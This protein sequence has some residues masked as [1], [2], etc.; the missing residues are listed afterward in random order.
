MDV[1]KAMLDIL[2]NKDI[3]LTASA[4]SSQN[5]SA[6]ARIAEAQ[7]AFRKLYKL[8]AATGGDTDAMIAAAL[9]AANGISSGPAAAS[10]GISPLGD[11]PFSPASGFSTSAADSDFEM[12]QRFPS[13]LKV[14]VP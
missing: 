1:S 10:G 5:N 12:R 13:R 14:L 11:Y 4:G 9:A 6:A 7:S 3:P 2:S 8:D